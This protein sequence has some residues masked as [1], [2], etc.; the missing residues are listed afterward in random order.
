MART[1][2]SARK[3]TGGKAPRKQLSAK[4]ARKAVSPA[5]S[6]GAKKSRYRPGSVALKEI[7]RYQKSTDFLI[8][9]LPFQRACR[10]VV[11]ECSNATDIRFQG[12]ALASI[13]EALE[14]Y[15]VGLFEDAMLC[16]CHAKRVTVFPK[17][18]NL[19]LKLRRRH[20]KSISD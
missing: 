19:V 10:S 13:Q 7:R 5:S 20:V 8:R 15:L 18:I 12:P 2:Q 4:S 17:D 6:A 16:A 14:V 9:R 11:K 1:K 3:T